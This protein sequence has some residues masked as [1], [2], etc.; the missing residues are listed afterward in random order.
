MNVPSVD[1]N[2]QTSK[3]GPGRP[4][5]V[6]DWKKVD[7]LLIVGCT[8]SEIA[9]AL[10]VH[11]D[12]IYRH[13][14]SEKGT[15][16]ASYAAD[17]RQKGNTLLRQAQFKKAMTGDNTMLIWLGKQTLDQK[18]SPEKTAYNEQAIQKLD[19]LMQQIDSLQDSK[20]KAVEVK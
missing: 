1:A 7:E 11:Q 2:S 16:F 17:R 13:V 12:T 4:E 15:N 5:H 6:I 8:G 9:A 3:N 18:E 14:Q 19:L 10:G 20:S